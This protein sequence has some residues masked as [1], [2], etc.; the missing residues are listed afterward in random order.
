MME[1]KE[2]RALFRTGDSIAIA[3][4]PSYLQANGLKPRDRVE[5]LFSGPYLIV[6]PVKNLPIKEA[7]EE[8][9]KTVK[10]V[11]SV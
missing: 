3:I 6:R 2:I 11:L 9:I 7:V 4:P 5:L 8:A 10:E 1:G